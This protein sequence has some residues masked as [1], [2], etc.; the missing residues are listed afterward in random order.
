MDISYKNKTG[1]DRLRFLIFAILLVVF[2]TSVMAVSLQETRCIE[3]KENIDKYSGGDT[4]RDR[5]M[6]FIYETR[7]TRSGCE[8]FETPDI[9]ALDPSPLGLSEDSP[10]ITVNSVVIL[11]SCEDLDGDGFNVTSNASEDCGPR[12]CNDNNNSIFPGA[13]E[14]CNNIDDDCDGETD[15]NC[16]GVCF[17]SDDMDYQTEGFVTI[18]NVHCEAT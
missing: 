18:D 16:D 7:Y 9:K 14:I 2:T 13:P 17:D 10:D 12:D 6:V 11:A 8:Q 15:E 4:W 3:Y 1:G 5:M